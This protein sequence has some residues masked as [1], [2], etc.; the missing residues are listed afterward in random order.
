MQNTVFPWVWKLQDF[1]T[2]AFDSPWRSVCLHDE[3]APADIESQ[4]LLHVMSLQSIAPTGF[5]AFPVVVK[6]LIQSYH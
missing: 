5:S 4:M 2:A 1:Q 3:Q 6:M